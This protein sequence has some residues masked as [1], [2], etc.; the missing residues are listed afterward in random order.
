MPPADPV[1]GGG[2]TIVLPCV[3]DGYVRDGTK[4]ERACFVAETALVTKRP[5]APGSGYGRTAFVC[6]QLPP[7]GG[8]VQRATLRVFAVSGDGGGRTVV[9]VHA[10]D[11]SWDEGTLCAASAPTPSPLPLASMRVGGFAC[12]LAWDVTSHVAEALRKGASRVAFALQNA[13]P[14][15]KTNQWGSRRAGADTAPQLELACA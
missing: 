15:E 3:A 6:F 14:S 1:R 5:D 12:Y 8:Q 7:R 10:A 11:S 4:Y 2:V 9:N 13:E